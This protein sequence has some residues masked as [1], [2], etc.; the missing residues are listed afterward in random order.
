LKQTNN[1]VDAEVAGT[2]TD[3]IGWKFKLALGG[4]CRIIASDSNG[5]ILSLPES[6]N[7]TD[8]QMYDTFLLYQAPFFFEAYV[9]KYAKNDGEVSIWRMG[10]V[11]KLWPNEVQ[12]F[13]ILEQIYFTEHP[14][15]FIDDKHSFP[16]LKDWHSKKDCCVVNIIYKKSTINTILK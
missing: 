2:G 3:G 4:K 15:Y 7:I 1:K 12:Y 16:W 8:I 9:V 11:L 5:S 6:L 10:L 13:V 14:F